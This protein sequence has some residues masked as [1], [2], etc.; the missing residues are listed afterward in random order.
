M[1]AEVQAGSKAADIFSDLAATVTGRAEIR[2]ARPNLLEPLLAR[3]TGKKA[4]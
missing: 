4:S 1:I 3:L 2:R